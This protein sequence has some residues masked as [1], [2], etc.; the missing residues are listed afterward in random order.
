MPFENS[1]SYGIANQD[2][3]IYVDCL[4]NIHEEIIALDKRALKEIEVARAMIVGHIPKKEEVE[5]YQM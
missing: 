5:A 1:I 3:Y 4:G 2:W